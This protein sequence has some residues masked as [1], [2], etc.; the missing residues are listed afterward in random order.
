ML[1]GLILMTKPN[2]QFSLMQQK[3]L[4]ERLVTSKKC[5]ELFL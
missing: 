2:L 3:A 4:F 1:H 5:F